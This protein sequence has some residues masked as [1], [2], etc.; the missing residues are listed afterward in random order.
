MDCRALGAEAA[1]EPGRRHGHRRLCR[2]V[3]FAV[4]A[5]SL[6][7]IYGLH[8]AIKFAHTKV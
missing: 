6:F 8:P 1:Q 4:L 2:W 3:D 7:L 5:D